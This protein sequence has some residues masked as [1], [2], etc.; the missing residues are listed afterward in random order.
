MFFVGLKIKKPRRVILTFLAL[1]LAVLFVSTSSVGAVKS[2][3]DEPEMR[4]AYLE[5]LGYE[6]D[7]NFETKTVKIPEVFSDVYENYNSLQKSQGYDLSLFKGEVV[8]QYIYTVKNYPSKS[9]VFIHLL[10]YDGVIIGADI[11][12]AEINGFMKPIK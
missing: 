9:E 12:S 5:A 10:I 11:M 1:I 7:E 6:I 8:T 4:A 2:G 3:Y